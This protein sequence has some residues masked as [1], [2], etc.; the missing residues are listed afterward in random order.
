MFGV[1]RQ[2]YYRAIKSEKQKQEIANQVVTLVQ[3]VRMRQ[4]ELGTRKLC[5]NLHIELKELRVGRDK[6][7]TILKAIHLFIRPKK[8]VSYNN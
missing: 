3:G 5:V 4:P 6:L 8:T 7:Y 2:V 1:S